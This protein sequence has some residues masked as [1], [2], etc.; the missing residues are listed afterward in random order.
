MQVLGLLIM[1]P[2]LFD[3]ERMGHSSQGLAARAVCDLLLH[4]SC[5][6]LIDRCV[7]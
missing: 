3:L 5:L 7:Y 1:E 2:G 4:G 6:A